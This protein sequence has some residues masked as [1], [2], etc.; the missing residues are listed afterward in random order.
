MLSKKINLEEVLEKFK[1]SPMPENAKRNF[2]WFLFKNHFH[3]LSRSILLFVVFFLG[4]FAGLF[5]YLSNGV[6]A[7]NYFDL[8]NIVV[9]SVSFMLLYSGLISLICYYFCFK[10]SPKILEYEK[11]Y[12]SKRKI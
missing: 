9:F 4:L 11:K 12:M 2:L 5:F 1:N 10:F 8:K 6:V 3:F 7:K